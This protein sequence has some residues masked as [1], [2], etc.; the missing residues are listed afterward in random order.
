MKPVMAAAILCVAAG[1]GS[2]HRLDEYLQNTIVSVERGRVHAQMFLTPGVAVFPLIVARIDTDRNG[3]ISGAEQRAY[4]GRV[5]RDLSL[6]V[7]GERLRPRL[8][9]LRFPPVEEMREGSGEIE[10]EFEAELPPVGRSRKLTIENRHESRISAYQVNC[11]VPDDPR[12]R[13]AAQRRNY[14]QSVYELD[15]EDTGEREESLFVS[16]LSRR[17]PWL[18]PIGLFL[19]VRLSLLW[20]RQRGG[21]SP[22]E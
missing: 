3:E 7:D 8:V 9:S 10:V 6:A 13:V 12:I 1:A 22:E 21:A 4:A 18:S 20:R 14:T 16:G 5:L 15:Y 11:L 19:L 17:L 2:A